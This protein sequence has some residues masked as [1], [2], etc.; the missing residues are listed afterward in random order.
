MN[1]QEVG[2]GSIDCIDLSQARDKWRAVVNE[3]VNLWVP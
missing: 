3:V 2:W 1:L